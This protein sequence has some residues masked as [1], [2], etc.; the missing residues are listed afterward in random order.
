MTQFDFPEKNST[1]ENFQ[2]EKNSTCIVYQNLHWTGFHCTFNVIRGHDLLCAVN[3]LKGLEFALNKTQFTNV[4]Y[5][6]QVR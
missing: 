3:I 4:A 2:A 6:D 1:G 5:N